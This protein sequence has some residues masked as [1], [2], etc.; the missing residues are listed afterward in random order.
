MSPELYPIAN[1]EQL[2]RHLLRHD[3]SADEIERR[4]EDNP[5]WRFAS[6]GDRSTCKR[7][8]TYRRLYDNAAAAVLARGEYPSAE[9]IAADVGKDERTVRRWQSGE[10]S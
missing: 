5:L 1:A 6:I 9:K 7:L 10:G 2:V 3:C 4:L 8:L